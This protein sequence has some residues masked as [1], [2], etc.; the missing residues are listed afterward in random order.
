[1]D[2]VGQSMP[3]TPNERETRVGG[4]KADGRHDVTLLY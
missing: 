2:L 4:S 3:F 1:M